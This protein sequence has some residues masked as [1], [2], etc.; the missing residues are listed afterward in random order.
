VQL[1]PQGT[2]KYTFGRG[3]QAP[4]AKCDR[5]SFSSRPVAGT[6]IFIPGATAF[7]GEI[8]FG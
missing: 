5:I 3:W 6:R 8:V 7:I 4:E 2:Q 1:T